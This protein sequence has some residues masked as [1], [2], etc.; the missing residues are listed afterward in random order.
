MKENNA[1]QTVVEYAS[2]DVK[3]CIGRVLGQC[4]GCVRAK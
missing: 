1:K 2:C 3:S 4:K